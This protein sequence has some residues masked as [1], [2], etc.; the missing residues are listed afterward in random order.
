MAHR[1]AAHRA[2]DERDQS[3]ENDGRWARAQPARRPASAQRVAVTRATSPKARTARAVAEPPPQEAVRTASAA[4]R[5]DEPSSEPTAPARSTASWEPFDRLAA[6]ASP[7]E[8]AT[9]ESATRW[10]DPAASVDTVTS[11]GR[12]GC[13]RLAAAPA[14]ETWTRRCRPHGTVGRAVQRRGE[15]SGLNAR[16]RRTVHRNDGR[17]IDRAAQHAR[18]RSS[19][20]I[21]DASGRVGLGLEHGLNDLPI[22]SG[23]NRIGHRSDQRRLGRPHRRDRPGDQRGGQPVGRTHRGRRVDRS[24]RDGGGGAVSDLGRSA[25]FRCRA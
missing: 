5:T 10:T 15:V 3:G 9:D 8:D 16:H 23:H 6:A 20:R 18:T 22:D 1:E 25:R 7:V 14:D 17:G 24:G 21:G 19:H 13:T 4:A 12:E 11:V 2:C